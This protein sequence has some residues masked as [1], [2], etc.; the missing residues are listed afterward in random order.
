MTKRLYI[1]HQTRVDIVAADS[2]AFVGAI[3]G[4]TR[5]H[6]IVILPDGK[7]AS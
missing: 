7:L 2:G 1:A 4:L 6:G 3:V 5:C